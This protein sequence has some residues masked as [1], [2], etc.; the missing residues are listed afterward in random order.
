MKLRSFF[1]VLTATVLVLLLV[2]GSGWLWL[3]A[4]SP[5]SLLPGN[6]AAPQAAIFISRQAPVTLSLLVNPDRLEALRQV[7]AA[8]SNR[9]RSGAELHQ[10]KQSLLA[11]IGLDYAQD[12]QPWLGEEITLA[13]TTLDIDRQPQNGRQ[14]G[15][16]LVLET[17]DPAQSQAS[18]QRFWQKQLPTDANPILEQYQGVELTSAPQLA[19]SRQ[20]D[21][22]STAGAS[23][24][25]T[26]SVGDRFVLLANHPKVLRS[27]INTVQAPDLGLAGAAYYRQALASLQQ[28]RI[29]LSFLNLPA[30]ATGEISTGLVGTPTYDNV[31]IAVGLNRQGILAET[32]LIPAASGAAASNP[33]LAD[34]VAALRYIPATSPFA[35][36][37]VALDQ[38]WSQFSAILAGYEQVASSLSQSLNDFQTRWGLD[39]PQD[40]FAWVQGEYAIGLVPHSPP[41]EGLHPDWLFIAESAELETVQQ[42]IQHLD[43][44]AEQ[45][46]LGVGPIAVE[47]QKTSAWTEL[48]TTPAQLQPQGAAGILEARVVG[49]HTAI[50]NYQVLATSLEA[51]NQALQAPDHSLSDSDNFKRAIAPLPSPNAGY[52]YLD[53][54]GSRPWLEQRFPLLRAVEVAGQPLFSHLRS[55]SLSSYGA[56]AGVYRSKIFLRLT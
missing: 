48:I 49:A 28:G 20:L 53:W 38:L 11:N 12:I 8:P 16:L 32:A 24:W 40:I 19:D 34:A 43:A 13:L 56:A 10:L 1:Y 6:Q 5:L 4:R 33:P 47:G 2:G 45:R 50:D 23:T 54:P 39:L 30:L 41:G 46:G 17:R 14:P 22:Q 42:A 52:L 55:L 18:L 9:R 36:S 44:V 35:L 7:I 31:A 25:A 15:W 3:F 37:G 27:A 26:A 21:S 29:G 51:V